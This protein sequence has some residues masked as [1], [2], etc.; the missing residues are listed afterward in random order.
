MQL[1]LIQ[2]RMCLEEEYLSEDGRKMNAGVLHGGKQKDGRAAWSK[3]L[4]YLHAEV[5]EAG[6]CW[7]KL[8]KTNKDEDNRATTLH[9]PEEGEPPAA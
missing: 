7:A 9:S 8:F 2:I 5:D 1:L 4:A 6:D 3:E